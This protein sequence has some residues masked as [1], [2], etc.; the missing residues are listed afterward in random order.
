MVE[1]TVQIVIIGESGSDCVTIGKFKRTAPRG[2][3][4]LPL[5]PHF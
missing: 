3:A 1:D 4:F 2:Q 5:N